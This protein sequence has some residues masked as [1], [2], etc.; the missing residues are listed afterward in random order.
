MHSCRVMLAAGLAVAAAWAQPAKVK[1][2]EREFRDRVYACWMGKNIGGTLGMPFE[3]K[4][5]AQNVSFYTN[6]KPGE[7]AANDDLDLQM[8]WL[9][10]ME[11]HGGRVDARILGEYWLKHVPVDW[12]EYGVGKKNM[13]RGLLPPLSGHFQNE[14]WR[15]SNGAWIRS[16]IWACL[17]PGVPALAARMAREDACVDHGAA[18]GTL[19]EIFTASLE[20]AAFIERDRDRLLDIGLAM[21][22]EG[23]GVA[24]AV[25]A[26][27][28]ARRAGKDWKAAREDVVRASEDTG[29]FQAPRN[30]AFTIIGWLYGEGDFGRSLCTAVNC[31][32]DTDCTGATLGSILG[33]LNG[34]AGIPEK[35]AR[36]IGT[37]IATV[38]ISGFDHP[39]DIA[40][41][42][43]GTVAM[44]KKVLAMNGAPV[45][46]VEGP[47]DLRR[48]KDLKLA[49]V[50]A[51]KKLWALSP[52]QVVWNAP[53][54]QVTLDY[55]SDPL[56]A[57]RTP[58][59]VRITIRNLARARRSFAV[60]V[61]GLPPNWKWVTGRGIGLNA[62]AVGT[63]EG[64]IV[65]DRVEARD[66]RLKIE[67]SGASEP[68]SLPLTL[69]GKI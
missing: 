36:P 64:W 39:K 27:R 46:L 15:P 29:W 14:K 51:A 52:Y 45:A 4:R 16:E 28:A 5:E 47:A 49:D 26:A 40:A 43:D 32:D 22:P 63:V 56:I 17:A 41:F 55:V 25:R 2:N 48:A 3:G 60:A 30:V 68:L 31:G 7:P 21:I 54:A 33:I 62:G 6:L 38:A 69:V 11:D 44:T 50:E 37:K 12:N 24:R 58:R 57:A 59:T 65:A 53:G 67:V 66:Y 18:E 61:A 1:L 8:L 20:S 9:K 34:T 19:A 10:A 35:W 23:C 42:T 13:R